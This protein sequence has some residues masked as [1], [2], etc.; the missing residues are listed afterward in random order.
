MWKSQQL[1][2]SSDLIMKSVIICDDLAFVAKAGAT[3]QRVGCRLDASARWNIKSWPVN[4]LKQAAMA[5]KTLI[6]AADAHL[7]VIQ[8]RHA[9]FLPFTL[10]VWLEGWAALRQIQDAALAVIDDGIDTGI[11]K[12]VSPELTR[13]VRK[14]G[15]NFIIAEGAVAK[16]ATKRFACERELP[17]PVKGSR[18]A[19]AVACDSFRG[20]GINE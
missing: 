14:H 8:A 9:H 6:G 11:T 4:A 12:T 13:F 15:L 20:F 16:D 18:F 10:R 7:I 5:E 3:L 2:A 1:L 19:S 17:L